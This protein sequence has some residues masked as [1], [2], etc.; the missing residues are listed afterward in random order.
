MSGN[1][2]GIKTRGY[3]I[4]IEC[5]GI[6]RNQAA[7]A[8]AKV[9]ESYA[10]N[11]G[12]SYDKYT[13]K[14]NKER[15]WSIVYDGSIKCIDRNRNAT[16]S[17]LYSVELNSPVLSYEDIPML[18]E[19][20]RAL[21]KAG[22]VTGAEYKCGIHIHISADDFDARSLRNLVNIFASKEDF[23]WEALQ[24]SS[25]RSGYCEKVD[26]RFLSELNKKK[27][28]TIEEI[29]RLWYNGESRR[30]S[31]YDSSRYRALNLH[32][33]FSGGHFEI[34]CCNS[35]LHAGV[36]RSYLTLALA[37]SN[38][39]VTKKYCSPKVS[40][41]DNMR[42]SFRVWLL[43]L[44]LIGEEYKNCRSHLLKH[45]DGNIAWRHPEDAIAQRERLRQER[46]AQ[47][48]QACANL[49][50]L[51]EEAEITPDEISEDCESE[52]EEEETEEMGMELS[53]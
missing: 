19:V 50:A 30:N 37:I 8:V 38:A 48:E 17:R 27:P 47:R 46:I 18:Q 41:S 14:D 53:M 44:G 6:T 28:K 23:L 5:T 29:E 9:L 3:G 51:A 49:S 4:E 13:I 7:K 43:N 26:Q 33:Y 36:I 15:K 39:A 16:S 34:R 2:E 22:A 42:Y 21:R 1:Y 20:V 11:E 12:G 10:V 32:S 52:F 45:L 40:R 25:M 31:H 35:S 24:V